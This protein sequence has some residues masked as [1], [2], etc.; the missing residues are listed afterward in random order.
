MGYIKEPEGVDFII[1]GKPLTDKQ[2]QEI[3]DFIKTDKANRLSLK[4]R[5]TKSRKNSKQPA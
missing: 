1:N 5:P 3:S 2:R 4:K